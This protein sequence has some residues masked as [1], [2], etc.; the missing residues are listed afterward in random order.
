MLTV[1]VD[2]QVIEERFADELKKRL[3]QIEKRLTFWDMKELCRQTCLSETT[4]KETFFYDK[5][6]QK[7]KV[8]RKWVFPAAEAEQFLLT[9][10]REQ[11]NG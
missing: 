8:G 2:E 9:W 1:Q 7:Y 4:I 6:F 11:P 3:A 10:I 5:R